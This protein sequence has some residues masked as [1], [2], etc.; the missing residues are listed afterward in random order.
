MKVQLAGGD[1]GNF[2]SEL[3]TIGEGRVPVQ[4]ELGEYNIAL[5]RRYILET[6][7]VHDLCSFVFDG[8]E[9][10]YNNPQWL[11]SRAILCPTN[12]AAD[13]INNHMMD[14]FPRTTATKVL[15]GTLMMATIGNIHRNSS[16]L[17]MSVVCHHIIFSSKKTVQLCS[18]EI[19]IQPTVIVMAHVT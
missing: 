15:V 5:P 11:C 7:D 4:H 1:E 10:Q 14:T 16:T 8:L 3:L 12:Q 18:F 6:Q 13:E 9:Q 19:W 17:F 2:A